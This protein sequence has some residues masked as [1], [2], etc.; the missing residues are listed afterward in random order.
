MIISVIVATANNLVIGK[1]N[2][3][4]WYLPADL[5]YFKKTTLNHHILMGR[6]VYESIG[7]ALPKRTN[8]IITRNPFYIASNC[9]TVHSLEEGIELAKANGEKELFIIGG[10]QIYDIAMPYADKLYWT[11]VDLDVEG[12]VYFPKINIENW[13][14]ISEENHEKDDKNEYNY[15]FLIFE[16]ILNA[17]T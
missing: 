16:R 17:D 10:G 1:D 11:T 5:K 15:S 8:V 7:K 2:Q 4:P 12:D 14:M 3:I 13:R 9:I 6:K